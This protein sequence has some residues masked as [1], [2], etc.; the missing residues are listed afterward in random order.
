MP[1]QQREPR[2]RTAATNAVH[3][4]AGLAETGGAVITPIYQSAQFLMRDENTYDAVRYIRL[5]NSPNHRVLQERLAA[6]EGGEASLVLASG[7][8]A[9]S[10]VILAFLGQGEHLLVQK[11]LYGGTQTLLDDD[12]PRF[13]IRSGVI[14]LADPAS[15]EAAR[16]PETRMLYVEAISNPLM[17][18]GDLRAAADFAKRHGLIS[19]IDST[20]ASPINFRP[21]EHGFDLVVHS[22]TKYLNG[23][24]D[25][26]AGVVVGSAEKVEKVRHLQLHLGAALDPH[27]CYLFERGLKT[28]GIR[29]AQQNR[30]AMQLAT[31]LSKHPRVARVAYPGLEGDPAHAHAKDLFDG[32]GGMLAFELAEGVEVEGFIARLRI[33]LHAPS[34]GG[35]ESL[36]VR[37]ATSSHLGMP[38]EE[39]RALG[40]A[41]G[42]IRVSVGIEDGD[43]LV[44]DFAQA[45]G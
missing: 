42:L 16:R 41:D 15:W 32:Y 44:E 28:L 43:E 33:P 6:L 23:H 35:V 8:A 29:V 40:I 4:G 5:H 30:N 19:V 14:D 20:F 24:S 26:V 36:V 17:E 22:A 12:L 37:P 25:L 38:P 31:F 2:Y 11:T 18:V 39:R 13:G 10:G 27:A 3:A 7:M 1:E 34:L 9:I 21:L 45:L